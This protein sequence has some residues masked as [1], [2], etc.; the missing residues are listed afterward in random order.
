MQNPIRTYY[1][2]VLNVYY[3]D[4]ETLLPDH[5]PF[6]ISG[7]KGHL[8]KASLITASEETPIEVE[9][10]VLPLHNMGVAAVRVLRN[11]V[12]LLREQFLLAS[13]GESMRTVVINLQIGETLITGKADNLYGNK[14]ICVCPSSDRLKYLLPAYTHYLALLAQGEELE[15]AFIGKNISKKNKAETVAIAAGKIKPEEAMETLEKYLCHFKEGHELCFPFFP[16]FGK[17]DLKLMENDFASI[18]DLLEDEKENTFSFGFNDQYLVKAID[19]GWL[20]A[21]SYKQLQ[22]LVPAILQPIQ[23]LLPAVFKKSK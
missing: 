10:G 17:E 18:M 9:T 14:L 21:V 13:A 6:E 3:K 23:L 8:Y 11:E 1:N 20:N 2:K 7:V 22:Q 4:E 16:A 5:E 12:D 19:H 15:F